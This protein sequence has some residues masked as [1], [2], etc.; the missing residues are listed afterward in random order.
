MH[1][2]KQY[3]YIATNM[4]ISLFCRNLH[5][6]ISFMRSFQ[7]SKVSTEIH[8]DEH[9]IHNSKNFKMHFLPLIQ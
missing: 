8:Q 3:Q 5:N 9:K 1:F 6:Y 4:Q 2:R 7:S